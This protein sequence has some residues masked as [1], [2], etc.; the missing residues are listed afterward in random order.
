MSGI[1]G[2][3]RKYSAQLVAQ[4]VEQ[5]A[6]RAPARVLDLEATEMSVVMDGAFYNQVDEIKLMELYRQHGVECLHYLNGDFAF[7][8]YD[9]AAQQLFGAVDRI[10]SKPL[11]YSL[12]QG[13]EFCSHLL[14]ICIGNKYSVDDY[15]RQCYFAMQ[16]VPAPHSM[17]HVVKKLAAA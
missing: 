4:K 9:P 13:F 10:G 5:L 15:A 7:V 16:Y 1:Y 17:V 8:I 14:P 6:Y 3:S 2:S 12:Q 11:Y